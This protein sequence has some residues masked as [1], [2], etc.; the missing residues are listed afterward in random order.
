MID[1]NLDNLSD[2]EK[3]IKEPVAAVKERSPPPP[4]EHVK[5]QFKPLEIKMMQFP[6]TSKH[7]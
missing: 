3:T 6:K 5:K 1:K 7:L 2:I 4:L